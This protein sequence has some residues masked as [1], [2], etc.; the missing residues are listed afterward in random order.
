MTQPLG[1]Q[2]RA[3][4]ME[5]FRQEGLRFTMQQVAEAMHISKK[6]IYTVYPSKEK[7]LMDMVDEAFEAIHSRKRALLASDAALE[8]KLHSV[9]I[10]LPEEYAAMDLRQMQALDEKYPAVAGRVR[11]H[12]ETGWEPTMALLEQAMEE[13]TIRRV[14][15]PVLRQMITAAI[16]AFLADR[17][18]EQAGV[19][20][21][22]A[23]EEMI[24]ILMEGVLP[25]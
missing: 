15:L 19:S 23:L 9:I 1:P 16:E 25:R 12:L 10:A 5:L 21:P 13:G 7:L 17:T 14:S 8:E 24:N 6:T 4:A 3:A 2:V 11:R 18:L 20:Y 22:A